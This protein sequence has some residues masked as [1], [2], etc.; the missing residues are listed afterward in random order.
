MC[1]TKR[2]SSPCEARSPWNFDIPRAEAAKGATQSCRRIA[3]SP[4]LGPLR[5]RMGGLAGGLE[6]VR[7]RSRHHLLGFV[8][9][10]WASS[11]PRCRAWVLVPIDRAL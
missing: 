5:V 3:F 4:S 7:A 10:G 9:A 6:R 11:P 2:A 8:E 1:A